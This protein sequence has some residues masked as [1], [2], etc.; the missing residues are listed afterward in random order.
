[1][2]EHGDVRAALDLLDHRVA[3]GERKRHEVCVD[4]EVIELTTV[5]RRVHAHP[6]E[7]IDRV[8][9]GELNA[10]GRIDHDRPVTDSRRLLGRHFLVGEGERRLGDHGAEPLEDIEIGPLVERGGSPQRPLDPEQDTDDRVVVP[11]RDVPD[12]NVLAQLDIEHGPLDETTRVQRLGGEIP[13]RLSHGL[14][15]EVLGDQRPAVIRTHLLEHHQ[16]RT[17]AW[18]RRRHRCHQQQ[19]GERQVR[20]Q[21]P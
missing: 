4:A 11:D 19:V 1:M 2:R 14:A 15:D 12:R 9:R 3:R 21:R 7:R 6:V 13:P 16:L 20:Q 18:R 8:G 10:T 5:R 17:G